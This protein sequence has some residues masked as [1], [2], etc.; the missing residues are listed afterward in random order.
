MGG[1]LTNE[2]ISYDMC[3]CF[4]SSTISC[5]PSLLPSL[6]FA[7]FF[8]VFG[9]QV[10][11]ETV[12]I[13]LSAL[14]S[15]LEN[16]KKRMVNVRKKKDDKKATDFIHVRTRLLPEASSQ[17]CHLDHQAPSLSA[18]LLLL[19]ALYQPRRPNAITVLRLDKV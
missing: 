13:L 8:G 9:F 14:L 10:R 1:F 4:S 19:V 2:N 11:Q 15:L 12:I 6:G 7:T 16:D 3:T 18:F 5:M 17:D